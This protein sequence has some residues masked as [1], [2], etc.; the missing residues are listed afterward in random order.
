MNNGEFSVDDIYN[1]MRNYIINGDY[2]NL[3][4]ILEYLINL[5]PNVFNNYNLLNRLIIKE[6]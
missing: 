6:I 2:I 5:D 1:D 3:E 4:N